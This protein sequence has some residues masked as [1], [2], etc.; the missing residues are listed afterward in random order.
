MLAEAKNGARWTRQ[1]NIARY[2]RI[3]NTPLTD[4]ERQYVEQRLAEEQAVDKRITCEET[5]PKSNAA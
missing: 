5:L 4:L 3:L 2:L 1:A